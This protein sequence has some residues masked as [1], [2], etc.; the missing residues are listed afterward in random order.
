MKKNNLYIFYKRGQRFKKIIIFILLFSFCNANQESINLEKH[1]QAWCI[2]WS[3]N[4]FLIANNLNKLDNQDSK[5]RIYYSGIKYNN[6]ARSYEAA[7]SVALNEQSKDKMYDEL[8]MNT[9][10]KINLTSISEF[11][12]RIIDLNDE[13]VMSVC[14]IWYESTK[15][16]NFYD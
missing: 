6:W 7:V 14:N 3:E 9:E 12:N 2:R 5:I 8:P 4:S 13:E 10:G 11:S 15:G 16:S 1:K